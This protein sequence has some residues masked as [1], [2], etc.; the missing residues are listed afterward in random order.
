MLLKWR[1]VLGWWWVSHRA[2]HVWVWLPFAWTQLAGVWTRWPAVCSL[3]DVSASFADLGRLR[4]RCLG[5]RAQPAGGTG[6]GLV[7]GHARWK[8]GTQPAAAKPYSFAFSPDIGWWELRKRYRF[9]KQVR[10]KVGLLRTPVA[11]VALKARSLDPLWTLCRSVASWLKQGTGRWE[12]RALYC[13]IRRW[14]IQEGTCPVWQISSSLSSQLCCGT[15]FPVR[16]LSWLHALKSALWGGLWKWFLLRITTHRGRNG[17][18][19][20]SHSTQSVF[21]SFLSFCV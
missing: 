19:W 2:L 10:K 17:Q 11:R 15:R 3:S 8:E 20:K 16:P 12:P 1:S 13:A 5:L 18:G 14:P 6:S 9:E 4:D 7:P 21:L